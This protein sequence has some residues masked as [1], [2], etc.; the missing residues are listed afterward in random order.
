MIIEWIF[1]GTDLAK[2]DADAHVGQCAIVL[3][4]TL[5]PDYFEGV[6]P[7]ALANRF[8]LHKAILSAQAA[9][10]RRRFGIKNRGQAHGWNFGKDA[11]K[12]SQTRKGGA[13]AKAAMSQ[14]K[15]RDS[16]LS[17]PGYCTRSLRAMRP[18]LSARWAMRAQFHNSRDGHGTD[19][20]SLVPSRSEV[21]CPLV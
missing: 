14:L 3:F 18:S 7:T 21:C 2:L 6:S 5:N 11:S 15:A 16:H 4:W 17:R 8:G 20:F 9:E 13:L 1:E 19:T 12:P 10:A